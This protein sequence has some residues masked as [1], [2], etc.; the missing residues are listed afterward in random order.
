MRRSLLAFPVTESMCP[1]EIFAPR[2]VNLA[3]VFLHQLFPALVARISAQ[4]GFLRSKFVSSAASFAL[5]GKLIPKVPVLLAFE[6]DVFQ[7][8]F[9]AGDFIPFRV[10]DE[11]VVRVSAVVSVLKIF[12]TSSIEAEYCIALRA[13]TNSGI[14]LKS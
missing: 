12:A 8:E 13:R 14:P 7:P 6:C 5:I 2:N 10:S 1:P 4:A 9:Q 3:L 11:P